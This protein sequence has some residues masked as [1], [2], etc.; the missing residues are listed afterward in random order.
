MFIVICK[1]NNWI[2]TGYL[3]VSKRDLYGFSLGKK[4]IS[5]DLGVRTTFYYDKS[6]A[7]YKA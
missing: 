3:S 2:I 6:N 7:S 5:H 4:P 1:L